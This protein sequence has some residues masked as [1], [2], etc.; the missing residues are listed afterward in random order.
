[1]AE[2]RDLS[3]VRQNQSGQAREL[4]KAKGWLP[5]INTFEFMV[6][7]Q[8]WTDFCLQ[9]P[10]EEVKKR[11]KAFDEIIESRMKAITIEE[12]GVLL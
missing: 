4:L 11:F 2:S 1:M 12:D 8:L 7:V 10:T 5:F 9:G 3:I 6:Y